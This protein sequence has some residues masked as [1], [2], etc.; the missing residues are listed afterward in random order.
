L[1]LT[2]FV[3]MVRSEFPDAATRARYLEWLCGGHAA[4]LVSEGGALRAEVAE[5]D[6]GVVETRYL[7][8]SREAFDAY[9]AGPAI[10]LRAD[11]AAKFPPSAGIRT[12]RSH[13]LIHDIV[14]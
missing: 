9:E 2:V 8:A 13:G 12:T 6:D 1:G 7:F 11:G 4:T 14:S 3:Y 5:L 10:A